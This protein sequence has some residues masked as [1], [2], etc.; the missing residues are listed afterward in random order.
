MGE[1]PVFRKHDRYKASS[2]RSYNFKMPERYDTAYFQTLCQVPLWHRVVVEE[3][4]PRIESVRILDVGCGTGTLL[5]D[6]A[7]CGAKS[8][9]GADL[10]PRILDVA[11]EKL[12]AAH[13]TVDLRVADV[14]EPLPWPPES[15]DVVTLTGALHH[16]YRPHAAL[17]DIYRVLAPVGR[18]LIVDPGFVTPLRQIFNAY[19]RLLPHDGDFHFYSSRAATALLAQAGFRCEVPRRVGLWAYLLV[20]AKPGAPARPAP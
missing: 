15:F 17:D 1:A 9:A 13:A 10:A 6:L 19:L 4:Q 20:G 5:A 3:L 14:E 16:F 8:L 18:L 7:R 2:Y 12:L 11:R